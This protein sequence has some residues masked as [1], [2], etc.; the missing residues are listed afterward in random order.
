MHVVCAQG[1]I[2]YLEVLVQ[3][4]LRHKFVVV[5]VVFVVVVLFFLGGGGL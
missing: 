3:L 1:S 2:E 4:V 5:V